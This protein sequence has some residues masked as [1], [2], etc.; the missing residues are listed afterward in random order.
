M[1]HIMKLTDEK[2]LDLYLAYLAYFL[3]ADKATVNSLVNRIIFHL[4]YRL[5]Y[6]YPLPSNGRRIQH[7]DTESSSL[8]V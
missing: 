7:H 1:A 5:H 6:F 4:F 3:L 2:I 8:E